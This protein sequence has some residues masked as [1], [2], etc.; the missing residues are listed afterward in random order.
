MAVVNNKKSTGLL[1]LQHWYCL[2]PIV[3]AI[4]FEYWRKYWQ[5]FLYAVSIWV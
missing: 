3:S 2:L 4:L 1:I 5:Y